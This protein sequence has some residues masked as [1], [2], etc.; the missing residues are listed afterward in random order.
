M[1]QECRA[2]GTHAAPFPRL[3]TQGGTRYFAP[4]L[5][6]RLTHRV[7]QGRL[8]RGDI[9]AVTLLNFTVEIRQRRAVFKRARL[10]LD[11]ALILS[12]PRQTI[13]R[14]TEPIGELPGIKYISRGGT[15]TALAQPL[16]LIPT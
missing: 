8:R 13:Q 4:F 5:Y 10:R 12:R 9:R 2:A 15:P 3:H 11:F 7:L 6:H 1:L 14:Q 16:P